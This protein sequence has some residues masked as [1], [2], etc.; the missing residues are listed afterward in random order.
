MAFSPR[1]YTMPAGCHTPMLLDLQ[2][3]L[4]LYLNDV[5]LQCG[6]STAFAPL[7]QHASNTSHSIDD[8]EYC[9]ESSRHCLPSTNSWQC[10]RLLPGPKTLAE[11][12]LLCTVH[13]VLLQDLWHEGSELKSGCKFTI[14]TEVCSAPP[15][16]QSNVGTKADITS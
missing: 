13:V 1:L 11:H 14:R 6:G 10:A 16:L 12:Q 4:Q 5:P 7:V 15:N 9:A 2:V 3:T 8:A